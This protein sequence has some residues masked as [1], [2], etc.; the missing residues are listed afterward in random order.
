MARHYR[1]LVRIENMINL[2]LSEQIL[3]DSNCWH[4]RFFRCWIDGSYNGQGHYQH[5]CDM[6][7]DNYH[8]DKAL[9][10]LAIS[11]WCDFLATEFNCSRGTVRNNMTRVF[12]GGE[13]D[14][15][16]DELID[17]LRELVAWEFE[18]ESA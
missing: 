5:N 3:S 17:D 13:L 12:T 10:N 9:R 2:E 15:L 16:N 4:R 14:R 11:E 1:E 18:G 7:R 8:D 6:V